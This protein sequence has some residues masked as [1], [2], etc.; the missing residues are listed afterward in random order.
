MHAFVVLVLLALPF[1]VIV[2]VIDWL[3]VTI[4]GETGRSK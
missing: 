2:G 1:V 4:G 3:V